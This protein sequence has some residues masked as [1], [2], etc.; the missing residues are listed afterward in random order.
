M[1]S[2]DLTDPL[3]VCGNETA[4]T[5]NVAAVSSAFWFTDYLLHVHAAHS[6]HTSCSSCGW[7]LVFRNISYRSFGR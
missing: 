1:V 5:S 4:A 2:A 6:S 3:C 7:F